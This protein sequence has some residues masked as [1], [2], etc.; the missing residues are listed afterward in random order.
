MSLVCP[1]C[2]AAN[3]EGSNYC[4][5]CGSLLQSSQDARTQFPAVPVSIPY[6]PWADTEPNRLKNQVERTSRGLVFLIAGLL[7]SSTPLGTTIGGILALLGAILVVFGRK[8]FGKTH[9]N[10]TLLSVALYC[11]GL[12][13]ILVS[14]IIFSLALTPASVSASSEPL[15]RYLS[16]RFAYLLIGGILGGAITNL[17]AVLFT[18]TLQKPTGRTL[19]WAAYLTNLAVSVLV[20][21][22]ISPSVEPAIDQSISGGVFDPSPLTDLQTSLQTLQLL[23][24]APALIFSVAYYM[25]RE[26]IKRREIPTPT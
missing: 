4:A 14:F 26:R 3:T 6:A 11:L 1:K 25:A 22:V 24:L 9:S 7:L 18:Y 2:G 15:P 23:G 8:A 16:I 17:A 20:Y 21:A 5:S 10:Y 13:V 12:V 19:L